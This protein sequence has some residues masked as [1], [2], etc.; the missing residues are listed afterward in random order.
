MTPLEM[1]PPKV[2]LFHRLAQY[3]ARQGLPV[4]WDNMTFAFKGGVTGPQSDITSG[5][6]WSQDYF[7]QMPQ[8]RVCTQLVHDQAIAVD[9]AVGP[10]A[11]ADAGKRN[12]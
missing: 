2:T 9:P 7:H 11:P 3:N 10:F 8:L 12:V 6:I 4:E 1:V 5:V